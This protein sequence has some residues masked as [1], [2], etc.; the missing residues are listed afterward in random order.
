[1]RKIILLMLAIIIL[2]HAGVVSSFFEIKQDFLKSKILENYSENDCFTIK[3]SLKEF[4]RRKI[5]D[6]EIIINK[7]F[8]DI[9]EIKTL[10]QSVVLKLISDRI[11]K[12]YLNKTKDYKEKSSAG[13]KSKNNNL[14]IKFLYCDPVADFFLVTN[15][16]VC[17]IQK[18]YINDLKVYLENEQGIESPPPECILMNKIV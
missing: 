13:A 2:M 16:I 3:L 18:L 17:D 15:N 4:L 9:I 8:H 10:H 12:S 11:E 7:E 14:K 1:M 5:S 6:N